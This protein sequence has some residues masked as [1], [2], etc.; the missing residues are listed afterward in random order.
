VIKH[1]NAIAI[2]LS[3]APLPVFV[4][5]TRTISATLSSGAREMDVRVWE[6]NTYHP[7]CSTNPAC[8][9]AGQNDRRQDLALLILAD[10]KHSTVRIPIPKLRRA[11]LMM[12]LMRV[13]MT[14]FQ[15]EVD[16]EV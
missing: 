4:G 7:R 13:I 16:I 1:V 2:P 6:R 11:E 5:W 12:M 3:L 10:L 9:R 14:H 15:Q 8:A